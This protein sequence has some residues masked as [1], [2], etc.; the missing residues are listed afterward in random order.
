MTT[1]ACIGL[2]VRDVIFTVD[3]LP[4]GPGKTHAS[5]RSEAGGGPAANAAVAVAGLGG[6]AWFIGVLADDDMGRLLIEELGSRRVDT[7]RVR[8]VEGRQSPLSSV[9]VDDTG[10]RAIVNHTDET[11][12]NTASPPSDDDL[13]GASAVLVDVR[14]PDGAE[15]GLR[16]ARDHQ[17]PGV[18]DYD[19]GDRRGSHLAELGSHVVFSAGALSRLTGASDP[20]EGLRKARELTSAW[21]AVTIGEEGTIWLDDDRPRHV[22]AFEVET[23]DTTGAGDVYHGVFALELARGTGEIEAMRL[24]SAAASLSCTRLGGRDG[25]PTRDDLTRFLEESQ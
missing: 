7:S 21:L 15:A 13:E 3:Q 2:A 20:G 23:V 8:R 6:E 17:V 5:G 12:F 19:F 16:W 14:W 24:A 18:V 22:P 4:T 9:I 1:V 25:V 11:M 10:E